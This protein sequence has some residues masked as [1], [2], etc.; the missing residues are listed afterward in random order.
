MRFKSA[1]WWVRLALSAWLCLS[2]VWWR[3]IAHPCRSRGPSGCGHLT[4]L[5]C[6]EPVVRALQGPHRDL[7]RSSG[8]YWPGGPEPGVFK[9]LPLDLAAKAYVDGAEQFRAIARSIN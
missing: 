1:F 2:S 4:Q 5:L 6:A 8:A 9:P 3:A 7:K